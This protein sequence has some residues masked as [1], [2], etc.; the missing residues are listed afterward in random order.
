MAPLTALL[1]VWDNFYRFLVGAGIAGSMGEEWGMGRTGRLVG[2][3]VAAML[4]RGS[5]APAGALTL[6]WVNG[7]FA[8]GDLTWSAPASTS[9]V[10]ADGDSDL[11]AKMNGCGDGSWQISRGATKGDVPATTHLTFDIEQ[12]RLEF[13]SLRMIIVSVTDPGRWANNL[14]N[15]DPALPTYDNQYWFDDQVLAWENWQAGPLTGHVDLNPIDANAY[16]IPGWTTM[17]AAERT[18]F[19]STS[20]HMT[21]VVYG[22]AAG[23]DGGATLDNVAWEI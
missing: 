19:L 17:S 16:N 22:C 13:Y 3:A 4:A 5:A 18:A 21:L 10:D 8:L 15:V 23:Y 14:L 11:E 9:F 20:L 2:W 7:D 12:G 1:S 6:P